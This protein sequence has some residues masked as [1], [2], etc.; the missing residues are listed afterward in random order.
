MGDLDLQQYREKKT[1]ALWSIQQDDLLAVHYETSGVLVAITELLICLIATYG[2]IRNLQ[3][4]GTSYLLWFIIGITSVIVILIVIALLL[5]AI[6]TENGRLLIP[7]LSAQ[8]C[9]CVTF[10]FGFF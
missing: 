10:L 6:K 5:Y 1:V 2:L 7:H 9:L 3:L 8:V 4:F